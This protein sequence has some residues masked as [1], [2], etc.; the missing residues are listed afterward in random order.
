MANTSLYNLKEAEIIGKKRI[1]RM[2]A[3][4][5]EV[6]LLQQIW[7]QLGTCLQC[8]PIGMTQGAL[9]TPSSEG[10][11]LAKASFTLLTGVL[12]GD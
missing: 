4:Y 11:C 3:K 1:K 10:L 8:T 9:S 7:E 6:V 5:D 12:P 2:M